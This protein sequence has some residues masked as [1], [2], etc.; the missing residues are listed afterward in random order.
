M[1]TEP[2]ST[3][4]AAR[5]LGKTRQTVRRW[6]ET[7]RIDCVRKEDGTYLIPQSTVE[8]LAKRMANRPLPAQRLMTVG[9]VARVLKFSEDHVRELC[10]KRVISY[11]PGP[12]VRIDERDVEAFI[13]RSKIPAITPGRI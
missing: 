11:L 1:S 5:I 6:C 10:H 9:E 13:D 7:G 8:A 2:L 4:E 12:P 3:V